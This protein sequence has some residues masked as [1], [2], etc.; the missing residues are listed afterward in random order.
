MTGV[1]SFRSA[2]DADRVNAFIAA[3]RT[4][5]TLDEMYERW[6]VRGEKGMPEIPRPQ[7]PD[8]HL[9]VGTTGIVEPYSFYEARS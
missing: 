5:G 1:S 7:A 3:I 4:D 6:V 9:K 2:S 8:W